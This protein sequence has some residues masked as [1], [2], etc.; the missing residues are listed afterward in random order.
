VKARFVLLPAAL[1]L[2]GCHHTAQDRSAAKSNVLPAVNTPAAVPPPK[3]VSQITEITLERN[4]SVSNGPWYALTLRSDGTATYIGKASTDKLGTYKT[5]FPREAFDPLSQSLEACHFEDFCPVF[6]SGM[7]H[8]PHVG[9]SIKK[10]DVR[11][12]IL[13]SGKAFEP[14]E[15]EAPPALKQIQQQIDAVVAKSTWVEVSRKDEL[16]NYVPSIDQIF[17]WHNR[18]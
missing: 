2:W 7:L 1:V 16:P 14:Y 5:L 4:P 9:V 12:T 8:T 18:K 15:K 10:K 3:P 6:G 17:Q 13:D 11:T